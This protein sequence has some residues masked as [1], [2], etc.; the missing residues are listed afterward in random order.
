MSR[1]EKNRGNGWIV[2]L[3]PP[4]YGCKNRKFWI[5]NSRQS[6]ASFF[7]W[8]ISESRFCSIV[9]P[10]LF[11]TFLSHFGV[12][13]KKEKK[14]KLSVLSW[15]SCLVCP[16]TFRSRNLYTRVIVVAVVGLGESHGSL[17]TPRKKWS[18]SE[19]FSAIGF[20]CLVLILNSNIKQYCL[21]TIE[22]NWM[23][24]HVV[25]LLVQQ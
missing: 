24:M 5:I 1:W 15:S 12:V 22:R 3:T 2:Y 13:T 6:Q 17:V 11:H 16:V 10:Y 4:G 19:L 21:T 20:P 8:E 14:K 23:G 9:D 25:E 18:N 7:T